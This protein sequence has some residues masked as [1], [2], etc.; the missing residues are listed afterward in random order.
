MAPQIQSKK[1]PDMR[2][3]KSRHLDHLGI[4]LKTEWL[5]T[6]LEG[7]SPEKTRPWLTARMPA[8]PSRAENL[9]EGFAHAAGISAATED[10]HPGSTETIAIGEKLVGIQG[11]SCNACHAIGDQPALG[12][13]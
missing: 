6:L 9:A 8:W 5:T 10:T 4:K 2:L 1:A 13:V 12:C 11:F 7:G 3:K